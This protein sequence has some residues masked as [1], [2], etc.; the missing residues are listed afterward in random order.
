MIKRVVISVI[1][2]SLFVSS[3]GLSQ[4]RD[5][6]LWVGVNRYVYAPQGSQTDL[7]VMFGHTHHYDQPNFWIP[8]I[9]SVWMVVCTTH[10]LDL[11]AVGPG[12]DESQSHWEAEFIQQDSAGNNYYTV[13]KTDT[14]VLTSYGHIL[15]LFV[16]VPNSIES[17]TPTYVTIDTCVFVDKNKIAYSAYVNGVGV[18]YVSEVKMFTFPVTMPGI[19]SISVPL[20]SFYWGEYGFIRPDDDWTFFNYWQGSVQPYYETYIEPSH[21]YLA[22]FNDHIITSKWNIRGEPI[23]FVVERPVGPGWFMVRVPYSCNGIPM[24]SIMSFPVGSVYNK[25]AYYFEGGMI[26][27]ETDTLRSGRSYL[28]P[29]FGPCEICIGWPELVVP[30]QGLAKARFDGEM[31]RKLADFVNEFGEEPEF[32]IQV[33]DQIELMSQKFQLYQNYPNP[34]NPSTTIRYN[35]SVGGHVKLIVYDL[36]GKEVTQLVSRHQLAGDYEV[37]W[38]ATGLSSGIYF[39][40]FQTGDFTASRQMI[41]LK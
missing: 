41:L 4:L 12:S 19:S 7:G 10:K 24:S 31:E 23:H 40:R 35:L 34:F 36:K 14:S 28:V 20:K 9:D 6:D 38:N 21:A 27:I 26:K 15:R 2:I 16:Q 1:L 17:R 30:G 11:V 29:V 18:V 25:I 22:M 37:E 39:C 32:K 5:E 8:N 3:L 13:V 33:Q